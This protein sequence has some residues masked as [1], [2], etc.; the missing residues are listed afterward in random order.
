MSRTQWQSSSANSKGSYAL[1][2]S[3]DQSDRA[4]GYTRSSGGMRWANCGGG[5]STNTISGS[6]RLM[7]RTAGTGS[8]YTDIQASC[9]LRYA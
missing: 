3:N 8:D 1:C 7:G 6:W 9:W 5:S 4:P 2:T